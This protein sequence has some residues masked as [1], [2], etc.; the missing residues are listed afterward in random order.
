[1]GMD[2]MP[3]HIKILYAYF[4]VIYP[5]IKNT[6][7]LTIRFRD[8]TALTLAMERKQRIWRRGRCSEK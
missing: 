8:Y 3:I 4:L 2:A 5:A 6:L 7:V 1:M